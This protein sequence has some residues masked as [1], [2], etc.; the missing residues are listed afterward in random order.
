MIFLNFMIINEIRPDDIYKWFITICEKDDKEITEI[1]KI[2]SIYKIF[3][4]SDIYINMSKD[5]KRKYTLKY[6]NDSFKNNI[7]LK[8]NYNDKKSYYNKIRYHQSYIIG[9]KYKNNF[10]I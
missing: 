5:D 7:H 6:F 10:V 9:Y 4:S 3:I 2:S 8:N 1:I